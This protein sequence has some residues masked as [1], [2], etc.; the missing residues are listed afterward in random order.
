MSKNKFGYKPPHEL[1]ENLWELT[2]EWSNKFGRRM[3]VVRFRDGRLAIHNAFQLREPELE[4]LSSLG[5][6][7][8]IIAPNVF[9]T[10]DAGWM[11]K[12]FPA[13][14]LFV[15]K[16]KLAAFSTLGFLPKDVNR[17]FPVSVANELCCIPMLGTRVEEAAFLHPPTKTL[18]LC[19]LAFNMEPVFS[20]FERLIMKWNKVGGRFGPS[21]LTKLVFTTDKNALLASYRQLLALDFDRV[22]VNHGEVLASGGR[23]KLRAGVAEIFGDF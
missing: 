15:P 3:T 14:E 6:P 17:E 13:A 20:G 18:I 19:D 4:W 22:I 11:G 5:T 1:A 23:E 10:S 21:R 7:A 12:K 8:F 9:H 2:G 16:K